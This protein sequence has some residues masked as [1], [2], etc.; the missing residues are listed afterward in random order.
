MI[1]A[2]DARKLRDGGIGTYIRGVLEAFAAEPNGDP[3]VALAD[4]EHRDRI[5]ARGPVRFAAVRA[6]NYGIA[7]HFAVPNAARAAQAT[8]LHE[9]HYTLPLF[10]SG[11][12][13]VTVHD[14]IHL[15]FPQFF[16][17]GAAWYARAMAGQAVR[18]A[19]VVITDSE[20]V[21]R[22]VIERLDA[23][24]DKVRTIPLG[25]SRAFA[26]PE[27]RSLATFHARHGLPRDYAL[28]VGARK[29]HK[30]LELLLD[31]WS[32]MGAADRP[33]LVLSG[34]PWT[35]D[36][37]LA[38]HARLKGVAS[39]VR[40]APHVTEERDLA[41]LYGGA[42]LYVQPS[43]AE[44]FGLPPLEAMACGTPVLSSDAGSLAEVLG[45]AARL[46]PPRDPEAWGA[47]IRELLSNSAERERL[48][49]LGL[50]RAAEFTWE[51]TAA[52]TRQAYQDAVK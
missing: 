26:R 37:R 41:Y 23:P 24:A 45:D 42:A 11:P 2:L 10:W 8:L 48:V 52:A 36:D 17:P 1:V 40:F 29:R 39:S 34:A 9:P 32:T 30:N 50:A 51:K 14:L 47:S 21:R 12:A 18:R 33:A 5:P 25:V 38:R 7:E 19:R 16:R 35:A 20:A 13:V 6:G 46:L 44:G 28:Y 31:A 3:V 49:A 4:P 22:D 15:R 43:L 27:P